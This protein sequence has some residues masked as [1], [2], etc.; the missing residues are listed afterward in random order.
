MSTID[1]LPIAK[2][3][4]PE[5]LVKYF[6]LTTH[7]L[8]HGTLHFY[9]EEYNILPEEYKKGEAT[10]KGFY[11]EI[12]VQDFPLRGKQ[13][14]LH[15]KRRRWQDKDSKQIVTRNWDLVAKGTRMTKEFSSFLKQID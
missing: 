14:Y 9:F 11:P 15:I 13:V 3:L 8:E 7:E 10:S 2:L 4:L 1:L 6:E 12:K 5:V